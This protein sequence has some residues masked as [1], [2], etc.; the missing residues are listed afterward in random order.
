[1]CKGNNYYNLL[2]VATSQP[3]NITKLFQ[4]IT[5]ATA[6]AAATPNQSKPG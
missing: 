5:Q 1:M 3:L 6:C 4:T 2:I